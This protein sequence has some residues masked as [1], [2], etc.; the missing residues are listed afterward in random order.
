MP[1]NTNQ[2][3]ST[4]IFFKKI[5]VSKFKTISCEWRQEFLRGGNYSQQNFRIPFSFI[6]SQTEYYIMNLVSNYKYNN[7][8]RS[9]ESIGSILNNNILFGEN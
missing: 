8:L 2:F 3:F 6:H 9:I 4:K 1:F 7:I 5:F